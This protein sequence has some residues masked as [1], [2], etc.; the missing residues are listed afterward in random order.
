[1]NKMSKKMEYALMALR[2]ICSKPEGVL[3]SAKEVSDQ[4]HIPFEV[5]ARVLQALS[6][7]GLLKA[8]YGM[9]GGY[10][11]AKSLGEIS[12]HDLNEMLEGHAVLTKCLGHDEPCE[13][14]ATCNIMSP[15]SNLNSK[16]KEFYKSISLQEV[17]HV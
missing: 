3:T 8:E 10:A 12:V 2:V 15:I 6:S 5:T 9:A 17:L 7:R 4:M 1:M 11:L 14:S 13:I 16:V